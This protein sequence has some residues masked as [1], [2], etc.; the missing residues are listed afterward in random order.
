VIRPATAVNGL[1]DGGGHATV[2]VSSLVTRILG[3]PPPPIDS[4]R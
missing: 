3:K 4:G 1:P 2:H